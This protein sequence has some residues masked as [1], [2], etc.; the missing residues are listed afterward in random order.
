MRNTKDRIFKKL[1]LMGLTIAIVIAAT[2]CTNTTESS[3][4]TPTVQSQEA[5]VSTSSESTAVDSSSAEASE[6]SVKQQTS[7]SSEDAL[8]KLVEYFKESGFTVGAKSNKM[9]ALI[10]AKGGFGI[11]LNGKQVEFY[12]YD[13]DSTEELTVTSLRTAKDGYIDM[14][15]MKIKVVLNGN[16]LLVVYDSHPDKDKIVELFKNYK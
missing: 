15:G 1:I 3:N 7:E 14:L 4:S 12:E 9:A 5:A 16:L 10:G 6:S 13:L 2:G 11:E 8:G